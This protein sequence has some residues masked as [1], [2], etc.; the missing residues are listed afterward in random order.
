M[1]PDCPMLDKSGRRHLVRKSYYV[2]WLEVVF[3][4]LVVV[5]EKHVTKQESRGQIPSSMLLT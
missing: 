3:R 1:R 5:V 4:I 2:Y